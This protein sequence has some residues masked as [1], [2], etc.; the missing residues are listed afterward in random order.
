MLEDFEQA[1][2]AWPPNGSIWSDLCA[3]AGL[4]SE[5]GP[6]RLFLRVPGRDSAEPRRK[7]SGALRSIRHRHSGVVLRW[8]RGLLC[9]SAGWR[10]T[11]VAFATVLRLASAEHLYV[12]VA[13][14]RRPAVLDTKFYYLIEPAIG[15]LGFGSFV[16]SRWFD[17]IQQHFGIWEDRRSDGVGPHPT[18]GPDKRLAHAEM[19]LDH[20]QQ[21]D[22]GAGCRRRSAPAA[23]LRR[24]AGRWWMAQRF[25]HTAEE[26]KPAA[27]RMTSRFVMA[28]GRLFRPVG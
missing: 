19:P 28:S 23:G 10:G 26:Q 21:A 25:V 11:P 7:H 24:D 16:S 13:V 1:T 18:G 15:S 27:G 22:F 4:R 17:V 8:D 6:L 9:R 5:R 14:P 12:C 2:R 3:A 20:H